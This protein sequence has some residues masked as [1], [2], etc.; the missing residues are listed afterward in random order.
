MKFVIALL[1]TAV[2][3]L[4][5]CPSSKTRKAAEVSYQFSGL[6]LDLAKAADKAYEAGALTVPQK[7]SV[8]STVRKMNEGAKAFNA[9]VTELA[10]QPEVP[11][12]KL[13]TLNLILSAQIIDPFLDLISKLGVAINVEQIKIAVASVR[14]AILTISNALGEYTAVDTRRLQDA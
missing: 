2:L 13:A 6:V 1:L 12:D 10:N 8:V 11:P 4:T 7:D 3:I 9:I 14:V 5:G